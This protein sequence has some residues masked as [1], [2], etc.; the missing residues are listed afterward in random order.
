[1][2]L[3]LRRSLTGLVAS[4][5]IIGASVPIAPAWADSIRDREWHLG[6]LKVDDAHRISQGAGIIVAVVDSGVDATHPDLIGSVLPGADVQPGATGDGRV[7]VDGHGTS[8]AGLIAGH[9]HGPGNSEGVLGIAPQ[10]MI[11][12]VRDGNHK[13][14]SMAE[15]ITWA[16]S[17]GAKVISISQGD[18]VGGLSDRQAVMD[19]LAHDIVVVAAAG[20][21]PG[22]SVGFPAAYPG[23]VAVSGVNQ[24]GGHAEVSLT[25]SE[26]VLSAPADKVLEIA[27]GHTY[28]LGTGTSDATA[29]VAGVAALVRAKYPNLSATEVVHRMTATATDKG[30]PGRDPVFG[31]GIVNPV[32]ALTAD[33]P[34]LATPSATK[35]VSPSAT[36][37]TPTAR[38]GFPSWLVG[39]GVGLLILVVIGLLV[40]RQ[41]RRPVT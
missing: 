4:L 37:T 18:F 5:V 28:G 36:A 9:G 39:V 24:Q 3:M 13:G 33:V 38:A 17:H 1:M 12:P 15:G 23:V 41:P 20:N 16:V 31:F 22:N 32:G 34:P 8:M 7:D 14:T 26:V 29:I 40:A 27:L 21:I 25:G 6:F 19:A 2:N 30:Q 11:L 35:A 10:A